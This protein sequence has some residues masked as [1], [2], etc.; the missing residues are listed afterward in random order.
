MACDLQDVDELGSNRR[1]SDH[2]CIGEPA[3][4][5]GFYKLVSGLRKN[6]R[7]VWRHTAL[8]DRYLSASPSAWNVQSLASL[9]ERCGWLSLPLETSAPSPDLSEAHWK[10][11]V[12]ATHGWTT[13]PSLFC[14]EVA[15]SDLPSPLGLLLTGTKISEVREFTGVFRLVAWRVNDRPVW[16]AVNA[17]QPFYLAYNG[18]AWMGQHD[19]GAKGGLICSLDGAATPDLCKAMWKVHSDG[20]WRPQPSLHCVE[21]NSS[22]LPPP[23]ALRID[24]SGEE[25]GLPLGL[26]KLV[27][28][29]GGRPAWAHV[30][31]ADTLLAFAQGGWFVQPTS[32][33][34]E[35]EGWLALD[36]ALSVTPH[37]SKECWRVMRKGRAEMLPEVTCVEVA[38]SELP[39]P[40]LLQLEGGEGACQSYMGRY[41]LIQGRIMHERPVWRNMEL[42]RIVL[43]Y[44]GY[45]WVVQKEKWM[46][47]AA[48]YITVHDDSMTPSRASGVWQAVEGD[49]WVPQPELRCV[50]ID[51]DEPHESGAILSA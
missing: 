39:T 6:G 10:M 4:C 3:R 30:E 2:G 9:G 41:K 38:E 27:A 15:T 17:P 29:I 23:F 21:V 33:L 13:R 24:S 18:F 48:G 42:H 5:L 19:P 43:A 34:G 20:R 22:Q 11:S 32:S 26:Y 28:E 44:G 16:R 45:S 47:S 49:E 1:K 12:G 14:R 7:P 36:D 46:G 51:P 25:D 8:P 31:R 35:R 37:E 40:P 50:E